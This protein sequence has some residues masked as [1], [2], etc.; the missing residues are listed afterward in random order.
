M[1][2]N[3][4]GGLQ[5]IVD[6]AMV[7]HYVGYT[8]NAAIGVSWQIWVVVIV[9]ISSLFTGMGVLVARFAGQD[10]HEK[11]NRTVYQAF[12]TSV[13][14]V[15]G[16]MAPI[17][18]FS[19]PWLLE[20]V[21]AAPEVQAE[22][23]PYL[24]IMFVFSF[25]MLVFFMLGGALRSA[26]DAQTPL[27]LGVALTI[28][29][30]TL[31]V[32]LIRGFGPIPAFGTKGAALGTVISAALVTAYAFVRLFEGRWVVQFHR[33]LGLRP[34]WGII[35]ELF[36]FGLP[37][38]IQGVAMN[39]GGVFLLAFVGSLAV[40]AEAQAAY[41]VSY[42]QIFSFITW[43]SVGLMGATAAVAGQ[44]LGAGRPERA[45]RAVHTAAGFGLLL[46]VLELSVE[47]L[48]YLSISGLFITV[49]LAYTGGLQGTGDTK[50]PMYISIVSQVA[51]PL[52]MCFAIQQLSTL[53]PHHIWLAIVIGHF[54]RAVLS[55][56]VFRREGWRDIEVDIGGARA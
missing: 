29:N 53:E 49:A 45:S 13:L 40:S 33:G 38:G 9:F 17:G 36:R 6:H 1:L 55:V 28:L 24:R 42:T 21:N 2:Q 22:A 32:V 47:L 44:N 3:I 20:L 25:G 26:G 52:G 15:V 8:G 34:D 51:I 18:Y 56:G 11:V 30:I 46:A 54:T 4:L 27:R 39:I 37:T 12:L 31:N 35:R 16:I 41:V 14:L 5:G 43:T 48:R 7:G 23:L 50:S 10:D 19:A